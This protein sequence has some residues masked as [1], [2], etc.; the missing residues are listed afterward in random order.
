MPIVSCFKKLTC[1][2]ITV[3]VTIQ[4]RLKNALSADQ[5]TPVV[6]VLLLLCCFHAIY[7]NDLQGIGNTSQKKHAGWLYSWE[8]IYFLLIFR[9]ARPSFFR[10]L[11]I[12]MRLQIL[13]WAPLSNKRPLF[14]GGKSKAPPS[15]PSILILYKQCLQAL[16]PFTLPRLPLRSPIFF[17]PR[18]FFS[19]FPPNASL[20]PG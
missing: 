4:P 2:F 19:P 7:L 13:F 18:R 15:L 14:K 12:M 16:P 8:Y 5:W 1:L 3:E 6:G 9:K 17:R 11:H 10:V 20:V